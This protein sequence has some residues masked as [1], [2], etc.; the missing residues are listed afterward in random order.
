MKLKRGE[1]QVRKVTVENGIVASWDV[2]SGS[3]WIS[4]YDERAEFEFNNDVLDDGVYKISFVPV[5]EDQG[6]DSIDDFKM[7]KWE[8]DC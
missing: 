5:G 3:L 7:E 6:M 8:E 1:K 2:I 4:G